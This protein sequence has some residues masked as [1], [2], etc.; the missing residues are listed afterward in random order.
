MAAINCIETIISGYHV[1]FTVTQLTYS[2]MLIKVI[3]L[4]TLV[5]SYW[6]TPW[7]VSWECHF[8][9]AQFKIHKTLDTCLVQFYF[10]LFSWCYSG[11]SMSNNHFLV[12]MYHKCNDLIA[13]ADQ[14]VFYNH[15]FSGWTSWNNTCVPWFLWPC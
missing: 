13:V 4:L 15:N 7:S 6:S 3:V 11:I 9:K 2:V 14:N 12:Q 1:V 10:P 8:G 5:T